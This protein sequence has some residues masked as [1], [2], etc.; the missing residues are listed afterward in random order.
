MSEIEGIALSLAIICATI[1]I[2]EGARRLYNRLHHTSLASGDSAGNQI[3]AL[4][5]IFLLVFAVFSME[6]PEVEE[7]IL[8]G[9]GFFVLEYLSYALFDHREKKKYYEK[10]E[11]EH[12]ENL[13][14]QEKME[15]SKKGEEENDEEDLLKDMH[16]IVTYASFGIKRDLPDYDLDQIWNASKKAGIVKETDEYRLTKKE[17]IDK[18][19][20]I[21]PK[22]T[23]QCEGSYKDDPAN[24][25]ILIFAVIDGKEYYA[26]SVDYDEFNRRKE[27]DPYIDLN[28]LESISM[29]FDYGKTKYFEFRDNKDPVLRYGDKVSCD[30]HMSFYGH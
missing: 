2:H 26:F 17:M 5:F 20:G 19:I 12:E 16:S 9:A 24:K 27:R 11:R 30:A 21:A 18:K 8:L 4:I 13:K 3:S 28:Y 7:A 10:L 6:L 15:S 1:F 14:K 22:Y 29:S 25:K 23:F